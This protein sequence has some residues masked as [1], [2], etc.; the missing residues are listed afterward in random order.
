M[1][2]CTHCGSYYS[3]PGTCNCYAEA[4]KSGS[5]RTDRMTDNEIMRAVERAS[6]TERSRVSRIPRFL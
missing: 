5:D 2:F 4:K 6:R 1:N 3:E